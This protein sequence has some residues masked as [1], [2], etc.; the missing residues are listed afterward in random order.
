MYY[1]S[2]WAQLSDTPRSI[3]VANMHLKMSILNQNR[4]NTFFVSH[5]SEMFENKSGVAFLGERNMR[6]DQN[7]VSRVPST[8][9]D[10]KKWSLLEWILKFM[11]IK[12]QPMLVVLPK[13]YHV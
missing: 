7:T 11:S 8:N 2:V 13:V 10:Q 6:G 3:E 4:L 12:N 9:S 1:R 5:L